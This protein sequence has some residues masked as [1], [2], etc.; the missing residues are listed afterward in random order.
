MLMKKVKFL[1]GDFIS[2]K[3]LVFKIQKIFTHLFFFDNSR[4]LFA[5]I[6]IAFDILY[7]AVLD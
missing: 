1:I 6:L 7:V 3:L 4:V 5:I 2:D